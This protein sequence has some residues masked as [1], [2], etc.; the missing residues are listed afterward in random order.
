MVKWRARE[1]VREFCRLVGELLQLIHLGATFEFRA[2]RELKRHV[3][4]RAGFLGVQVRLVSF[5][6]GG[7]FLGGDGH[8]LDRILRFK[9]DE[10]RR[11]RLQNP[12]TVP[13]FLLS[14]RNRRFYDRFDFFQPQGVANHLLE[15]HL[16]KSSWSKLVPD[17]GR[18]FQRVKL[19]VCLKNRDGFDPVGD[20]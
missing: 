6:K 9:P 13:D 1:G 11:H 16:G 14:D 17:K 12:S 19:V 4:D 2:L 5:K 3:A 8:G 10:L 15:L 18:I 7:D 20:L